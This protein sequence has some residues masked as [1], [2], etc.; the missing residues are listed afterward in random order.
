MAG[1]FFF[2]FFF[3]NPLPGS[4]HLQP[5][6]LWLRLVLSHLAGP[7]GTVHHFLWE[8]SMPCLQSSTSAVCLVYFEPNVRKKK[9]MALRSKF[10]KCLFFHTPPS[11]LKSRCCSF[12]QCGYQQI[13]RCNLCLYVRGGR[14]AASVLL[15]LI[16]PQ[17]CVTVL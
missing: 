14:A 12:V 7:C 4:S 3:F 2:S 8:T 13:E 1:L 6:N 17:V 5:P 15:P 16:G 11:F 10:S 9:K